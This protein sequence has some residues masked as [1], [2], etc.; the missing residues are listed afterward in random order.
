MVSILNYNSFENTVETVEC[1]LNQTYNNMAVQV[2]DNASTDGCVDKLAQ[3]FPD[4]TINRQNLNIGYV[5]GNN[6]ALDQG[7]LEGYDLVV[8]SNEDIRIESDFI[9]SMVETM[10]SDPEIGVLGGV[11][12]NYYTNEV[13]AADASEFNFWI[14]R[15]SWSANTRPSCAKYEVPYVQ[16]AAVGFTRKAL[17]RN[18]RYDDKLFIYLDEVDLGIALRQH[19]LKVVVDPRCKVYHKCRP[20]R[21][22][23]R[24]AYLIQRN[25]IYLVKKHAA[26]P[27]LI[28]NIFFTGLVEL[29][30][31]SIFRCLQGQR[32]FVK[33]C[34]LGYFDGIRGYMHQGRIFSL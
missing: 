29:P 26:L 15:Q 23:S 17:E 32:R 34:W 21:F 27:M 5:G 24:T 18:I 16:G 30:V 31:K 11:E 3:V 19:N 4:L 28:F 7:I 6:V 20:R 1:Y 14:A 9:A 25:R 13:K 22:N 2:V 33:A 12:I 8:I 10:K